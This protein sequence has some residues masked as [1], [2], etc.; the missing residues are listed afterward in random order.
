[1]SSTRPAPHSG[2]ESNAARKLPASGRAGRQ[3]HRAFHQPPVQIRLDQPG[4][5]VEQRALGKRRLIS[6]QTVQHQLPAPVHHRRLDHL[7]IRGAGV[8]LQDQRQGQ[9][10]RRH[11]RLPLGAIGIH[12]GQLGL[13]LLAEQLMAM[14]PQQHKQLR[15]PDPFDNLLLGR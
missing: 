6:V 4:P 3:R 14:L 7:I 8:G 12:P 13:E 15:P 2:L 11:R 5:E 9:L 1:V 10:R